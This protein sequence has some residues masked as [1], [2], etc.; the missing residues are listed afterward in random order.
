MNRRV[1]VVDD[2]E[3]HAEVLAEALQGAG[4]EVRV[5]TGGKEGVALIADEATFAVV[6]TDLRM[7]DADGFAVLE[8]AVERD[9]ATQVLMLTGHGSR[10][11]A[12]EAMK[13]GAVYYLEKPVDLD[14]LRVKV[15]RGLTGFDREQAYLQLKSDVARQQGIEGFVGRSPQVMRIVDLVHQV[16]PTQASVLILGESGSGKELVARAIHNLSPRR[17]R[18]FV[19]VNCGGLPEGTL[20]SELFGHRKGAFTGAVG[21]RE[22]RFEFARGGTIFLDEIAEMPVAAQVKLL[23]VLEE[24]SVVPVGGNE[25]RPVDVRVLAATHQDLPRLIEDGRFRED[26]YYRLK[27]VTISVPSLRDRKQ[28]IPLLADHFRKEAAE[29]H[30]KHV[31]GIDRDV[32]VAFSNHD[33]PGNV[34][35]LRNVVESMVVR[36]R[37]NILTTMDLP[38]ELDPH[39]RNDQDSWQFLAGKDAQEVERQHLRVTLE[40]YGGN[41]QQAAKAMGISERTLYRKL[42]EYGL[43]GGR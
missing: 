24:R 30:D 13:K 36:A 27:V 26:L 32:L 37:G 41:R 16:A 22:G 12:V 5:A 17:D 4:C 2:D 1:L 23:R 34:R 39:P 25:G 40:M 28:D 43:E 19:A 8:A 42:K 15:E 10:E 3:G 18:P 35:E 29:L 38:P 7:K 31:D 6:V 20:E 14:E 33:W 11:V 21:D 9:P